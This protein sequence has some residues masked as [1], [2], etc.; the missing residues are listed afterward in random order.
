VTGVTSHCAEDEP[1]P[2]HDGLAAAEGQAAQAGTDRRLG[3]SE[4]VREPL[5]QLEVDLQ[6][7]ARRQR[8]PLVQRYVRIIAALE[9]LQK[10]Q[11][12]GAGVFD[13][14]PHG[15]RDIA[16][17]PATEIERPRLSV[18]GEHAHA[19]LAADVILPFVGVGMPVQLPQAARIDLDKRGRNPL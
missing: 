1:R 19:P 13:I 6:E 5:I 7:F 15:E 10:A 12:R 18:G 11:R 16:D 3:L 14:V 4:R 2:R 9:D 17:V 8:P